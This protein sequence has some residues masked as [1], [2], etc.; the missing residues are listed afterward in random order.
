MSVIPARSRPGQNFDP[1]RPLNM[2]NRNSE[3]LFSFSQNYIREGNRE[4][5]ADIINVT[6][7]ADAEIDVELIKKFNI[8]LCPDCGSDL[9]KPQ[10]NRI[11]L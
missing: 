5:E 2:T 6:P 8:P 11:F 3:L 7:D 4:F 10:V 1:G 9:L